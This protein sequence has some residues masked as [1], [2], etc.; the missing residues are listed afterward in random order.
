MVKEER[1]FE[2]IFLKMTDLCES[3]LERV[4][5]VSKNIQLIADLNYSDIAI[6][7][8]SKDGGAVAVAAAKPNTSVSVREETIVGKV[9][10]KAPKA[11][12]EAFKKRRRVEYKVSEDKTGILKISAIPIKEG[13]KVIAVMTSERRSPRDWRPSEMEQIYMSAAEDLI[14]MIESGIDVGITFPTS[15]EVGD[16][17]LRIDPNGIVIYA[18]PN[19][20]SI[21]RRLGIEASLVG[22]PIGKLGLDESP[23]LTALEDRKAVKKEIKERGLTVIKRAIPLIENDRLKGVVSIV[24]DV[25]EVR[26]REQ[27]LRIKEATIREIHH[28]VKNNLQTIASL[29]RLQARRM[30]SPEAREAL[31]ESVGRISSIAAVHEILSQSSK[32]I[33][34]FKEVAENITS[35]FKRSFVT[36]EKE[37]E[38][39]VE[40]YSGEVASSVATSL[41]LV[42]T[43]LTQNALEH[44]FSGR[45]KGKI[46][47]E[48]KREDRRLTMK[49]IDDGIGVS[50]KSGAACRHHL[51][52]QIVQTLVTDELSGKWTTEGSS[53]GTTVTVEIP[54][55]KR[56]A[57]NLEAQ[58]E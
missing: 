38:I 49:V 52:L 20:I 50:K 3:Q 5:A 15:K 17:L 11:V 48:L 10:A 6:F 9:F 36:K 22:Q 27:Q 47:V 32:S 42:L 39:E 25:T 37:I 41:A 26:A 21:Y 58:F 1:L 33:I 28:R 53:K 2:S 8:R 57:V 54:L 31:L 51:G 7:C 16:G 4:R 14:Q 43:E 35:M 46:R 24:R 34:D 40:G 55:P 29:L 13:D 18:T 23:V 44:A 30:S 12:E 56:T 19:A 45:K